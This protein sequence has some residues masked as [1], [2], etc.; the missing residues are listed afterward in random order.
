MKKREYLSPTAIKTYYED[1]DKFYL[2][3]LSESP[4]PKALQTQPMSIGSAFDAYVKS[5]LHGVIY[6]NNSDPRFEFQTLFEAQVEPH[7]RD[8]AL[9]H[10]KYAYECYVKSGALADLL[11]ELQEASED[12]IF[13]IEVRGII[14][15]KREGIT[16]EV[17]G[18]TLLGKPDLYFKN[19]ENFA[20]VRDWKVNGWCSNSPVSPAKGYIKLRHSN[21]PTGH[22]GHHKEAFP[23]RYKGAT[24]N[25]NNPLDTVN[26]DWAEQVAIYGW[27]LGEPVGSGFLV[28]IDQLVCKP[29]HPFPIV[30]IAE[31]RTIIT[32]SFQWD[33][34]QRALKVW[35]VIHSDWIFRDM[36]KLESQGKCKMLD[37]RCKAE[38]ERREK[39]DPGVELM[40]EE[41]TK[42]PNTF[43]K[44]G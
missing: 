8:W 32:P 25:L 40:F 12:P 16:R 35:D 2:W 42:K 24:V 22:D 3:Y 43:G 21:G 14:E 44:R 38:A 19:K 29:N 20:V 13:E 4:P 34:Y 26:K 18:M 28:G 37:D 1:L 41:L 10:G 39:G 11:I 31:H 5:Y 36:T 33:L 27:L 15:G 9:V 6:G 7:N 17:E 23:I 30:R